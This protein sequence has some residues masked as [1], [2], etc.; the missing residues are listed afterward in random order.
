MSGTAVVSEAPRVSVILCGTSSDDVT[1]ANEAFAKRKDVAL[2]VHL[3]QA[4]PLNWDESSKTG[5][6]EALCFL[7]H[8][9]TSSEA[10]GDVTVFSPASCRG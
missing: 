5:G 1:W 6:G 8:I 9:M 2:S 7:R 10:I 3:Q 4:A